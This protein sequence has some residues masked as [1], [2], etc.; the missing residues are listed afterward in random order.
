MGLYAFR[1]AALEAF[2]DLAPS[3][4][5]QGERLEQLRLLENGIPIRVV[6][7][8]EP[9]VGVDTEADVR[10]AEAALRARDL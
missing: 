4:L 10:A 6:E 7:T 2:H 5:E 9:T 3:S 1:R 8:E